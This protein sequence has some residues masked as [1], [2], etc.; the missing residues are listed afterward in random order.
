MF[1]KC[2]LRVS[3]FKSLFIEMAVKSVLGKSEPVAAGGKG[4]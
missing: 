3:I 2:F 4:G 1:S